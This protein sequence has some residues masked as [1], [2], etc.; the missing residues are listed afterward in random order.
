MNGTSFLNPRYLTFARTAFSVLL[1]LFSVEVLLANGNACCGPAGAYP[2]DAAGCEQAYPARCAQVVLSQIA[3]CCG[4]GNGIAVCKRIT[5]CG[6]ETA[7]CVTC[8]GGGSCGNCQT[9]QCGG[10]TCDPMGTNEMNCIA[11]GGTWDPGFCY[12]NYTP[13]VIQLRADGPRYELTSIDEG[14]LFDHNGDGVKE[15]TAWTVPT[16]SE[17]LLSL[18]RNGSGHIESGWL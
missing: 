2:C 18:D 17:G 1:S 5:S 8:N 10:G 12:C 3:S 6:P 9:Q 13:I 15:Q 11:D 4:T 7:W 16:A 14:V